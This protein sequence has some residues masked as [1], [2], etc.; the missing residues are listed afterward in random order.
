MAYSHPIAEV[1]SCNQSDSILRT[2]IILD[3]TE[4]VPIA[5]ASLWLGDPP[6]EKDAHPIFQLHSL[7]QRNGRIFEFETYEEY[8]LQRQF[9]SEGLKYYFVSWWSRDQLAVAQ[10]NLKAFK[11]YL[12]VPHS[13][14]DHDHCW[15]CWKN[16][17]DVEENDNEAYVI[18]PHCICLACYDKY[19]VS[20][21][22]K[23]LADGTRQRKSLLVRLLQALR[24]RT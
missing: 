17:S 5:P 3:R 24:R 18:G 9:P 4:A 7:F 23:R 8:L 10:S 20:G 2:R 11:R 19:I 22:G 16:I 6:M 21:F 12:F 1:V 15:L 13:Y 14:G